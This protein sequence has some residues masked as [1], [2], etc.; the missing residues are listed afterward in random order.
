MVNNRTIG[1]Q[2]SRQRLIP[3]PVLCIILQKGGMR[4]K[5]KYSGYM[6][7]IM[8]VDLTTETVREYP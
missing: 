1:T 3:L 7:K 4:M 6:G 5:S 2:K 8:E